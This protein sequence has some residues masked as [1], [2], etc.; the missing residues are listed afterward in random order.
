MSAPWY[1]PQGIEKVRKGSSDTAATPAVP[2]STVN[3]TNT[4]G[5]KVLVNIAGGTVTA[6]KVDGNTV[7]TGTGV[8]VV[9]PHNKTISI[10]YS[11]APTWTWA[12]L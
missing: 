4:T 7:A 6:V 8:S 10:T 2:A 12:T 11:V 1:D 3:I 5:S 9:V